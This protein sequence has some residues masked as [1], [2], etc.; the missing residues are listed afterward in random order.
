MST[1]PVPQPVVQFTHV[2]EI[3]YAHERNVITKAEARRLLGFAPTVSGTA[4]SGSK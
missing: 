1:P 3:L 4:T 2:N